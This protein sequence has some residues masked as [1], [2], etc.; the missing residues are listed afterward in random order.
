MAEFVPN[1]TSAFAAKVFGALNA[2]MTLTNVPRICTIAT[3]VPTVSICPVGITV[4][5]RPDT[6]LHSKTIQLVY[7]FVAK[8]I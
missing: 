5:V 7:K 8:V 3:Q 1:Q 6:K 4:S 2:K